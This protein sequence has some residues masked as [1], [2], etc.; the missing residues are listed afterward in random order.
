MILIVSD[1]KY[2]NDKIVIYGITEIG[3]I[4]GIWK[5]NEMPILLNK[6]SVELTFK[7]FEKQISIEYEEEIYAEIWAIDNTVHFHGICEDLDE[8]VY[9]VRFATDW[10]DMIEIPE[11][12]T[13]IK[14]GNHISFSAKYENIWIYPYF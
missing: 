11:S 13:E 3:I 9:Y 1:I 12:N 4:K 5:S 6:Y 2:D 8:D 7:M 10:L 14:K